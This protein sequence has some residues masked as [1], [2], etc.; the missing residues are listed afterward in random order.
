[1][2]VIDNFLSDDDWSL[3][4]NT[5]INDIL[6]GYLP[7]Y[8]T[9]FVSSKNDG[10]NQILNYYFEHHIYR[11]HK[12]FSDELYAFTLDKIL[13]KLDLK[14]FIRIKLNAYPNI[15]ILREHNPHIDYDF[16]HKGA[17]LFLNTCNGFTRIENE[18]VESIENRIVFFEPNK[19][20]NSS[21]CTDQKLRLTINFNYL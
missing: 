9:P 8:F 3:L 6:T 14:A 12:V 15:G 19:Y 16:P 21:T 20:H 4:K 7:L 11:E 5:Y 10:E 18:K 2:K 13:P 17:L 1:M